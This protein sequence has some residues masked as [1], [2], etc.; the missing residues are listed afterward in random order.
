[1]IKEYQYLLT[2]LNCFI[3]DQKPDPF[4][5][6]LS[7][8]FQTADRH[9]LMGIVGYMLTKYPD[10]AV[11]EK[12]IEIRKGYLKYIGY[13]SQTAQL[14]KVLI[15]KLNEQEIDHLLMKG[16]VVKDYYPVPELR[17]YGDIDFLIR[18]E[19]RKK[20]DDLMVSS[21]FRKKKDWEPVYNYVKG[22]EHYE[23]HTEI[24]EVDVSKKADYRE[25]FSHTWERAKLLEGH[26]YVLSPED[27][28]IYLLTHIAK[29][30]NGSGAGVRMYLDIAVYMKHF[31][32]KMDLNYLRGELEKL[33]LLPFTNFVFDLIRVY[34]D[35]DVKGWKSNVSKEELE[36]FMTMTFDGGTFGTVGR[37]AGLI[38]LKQAEKTE[39]AVSRVKIVLNRLFPAAK[40]IEN[41]YTY[42]QG[43]HWLIPVAWIHRLV[44]TRKSFARHAKEARD[45]INTDQAEVDRM[46]K[47]YRMLDL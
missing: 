30:I 15:S 3:H 23:I 21:G 5:G 47:L 25:Y 37:D 40:T 27:H 32:N 20:S 42:L 43:K 26:S 2:I 13:F 33:A 8:L 17:T 1:M 39:N 10:E 38:T 28:L 14:M 16:F 46:K 29:H 4:E 6:D 19:D 36:E 12:E 35:V 41:R 44:I 31:E 9:F 11:R 18:K 24:M 34:F 45:I 7:K 22:T